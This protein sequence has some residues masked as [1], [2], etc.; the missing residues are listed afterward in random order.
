[1]PLMYD[2]RVTPL[3]E[4]IEELLADQKAP[5][6]LVHFTQAAAIERAQAL[7]SINVCTKRGEGRA[8]PS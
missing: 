7:M 2:Y 6:Y 5:V 4:T 3:H 1:M 8:S